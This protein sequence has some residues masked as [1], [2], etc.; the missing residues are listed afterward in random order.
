MTATL[1]VPSLSGIFGE[2]GNT[3]NTLTVTAKDATS[4]SLTAL[5]KIIPSE[6]V[7][8]PPYIRVYQQFQ[9]L[10]T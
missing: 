8:I 1:N 9:Y 2:Q 4:L 3:S 5:M 6:N 7:E 10:A